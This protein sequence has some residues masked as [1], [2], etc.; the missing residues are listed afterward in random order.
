MKYKVYSIDQKD[1]RK[2]RLK[3][4]IEQ[5]AE[6]ESEISLLQYRINQ[7]EKEVQD[8]NRR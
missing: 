7:D 3:Q 2:V 5:K 1:I 8:D 6:I 4:L